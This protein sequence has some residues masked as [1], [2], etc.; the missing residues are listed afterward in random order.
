M[1]AEIKT[2]QPQSWIELNPSSP[3]HRTRILYFVGELNPSSPTKAKYWLM[4]LYF[5][6]VKNVCS[7]TFLC[8][9]QRD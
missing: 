5:A 2:V 3:R 6:I 7:A 4:I 9:L 8:F 1:K